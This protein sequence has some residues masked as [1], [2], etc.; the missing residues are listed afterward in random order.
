MSEKK[1]KAKDLAIR[2][3]DEGYVLINSH[4][5]NISGKFDPPVILV[6]AYCFVPRSREDIVERYGQTGGTIYDKLAS[7]GFLS[8][9]G[10]EDETPA[11]FNAFANINI[12]R[13]MLDDR[14]RLGKYRQAIEEK[15][16]KGDRVIDAGTGSG[17]LAMYA[18]RAGAAKVFAIDNSQFISL[19][20]QVIMDNSLQNTIELIK[21]DFSKVTLP[22][23]AQCLVTETFGVMY[24]TEGAAS[25]IGKC[26]KNNLETGGTI[27][28]KKISLFMA[29]IKKAPSELLSVFEDRDDGINLGRLKERA[30]HKAT[31]DFVPKDNIGE[32]VCLATFP[33]TMDITDQ[34]L[35]IE[36]VIP[37]PCEALCGWF[38]LHLT[39][40]IIFSTAPGSTSTSWHQVLFPISLPEGEH[41]IKISFGMRDENRRYMYVHFHGPV[42]RRVEI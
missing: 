13:A 23:K 38:D 36:T 25:D 4:S 17:I 11:F 41:R 22:E 10:E 1:I 33:V 31:L 3:D 35:T 8:T 21:D 37:G 6:L 9:P 15:V 18:A 42:N 19:T 14:E 40:S 34:E 32:P 5:K 12:H 30:S 26:A 16:K 29:P 24:F 28:P 2:I 39:E 7:H 20:E 27:I